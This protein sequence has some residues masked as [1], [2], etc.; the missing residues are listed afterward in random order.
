[1]SSTFPLV[2]GHFGRF[3]R[4]SSRFGD[5]RGETL[6]RTPTHAPPIIWTPGASSQPARFLRLRAAPKS[7]AKVLR[8][9]WAPQD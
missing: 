2:P 8:T 4:P 1:M 9:V 6:P 5:G 3:G 7:G